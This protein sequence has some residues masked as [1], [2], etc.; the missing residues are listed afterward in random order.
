MAARSSALKPAE[1][2]S[3]SFVGILGLPSNGLGHVLAL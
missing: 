2:V 1:S 3:A